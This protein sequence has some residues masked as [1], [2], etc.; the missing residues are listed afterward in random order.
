MLCFLLVLLHNWGTYL[1][2]N[3]GGECNGGGDCNGGGGSGGGDSC[4]D[5][6]SCG[7]N[8]SSAESRWPSILDQ[9]LD[10]SLD[11]VL[12]DALDKSLDKSLDALLF[13]ETMALWKS[14]SVFIKSAWSQNFTNA[15]FIS[16]K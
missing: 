3:G 2:A 13:P 5:G 14:L 16:L 15:V 8:G 6:D 9:S 11:E 10:K 12:D 1:P 7:G 4:S